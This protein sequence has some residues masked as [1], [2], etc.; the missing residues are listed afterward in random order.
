LTLPHGTSSRDSRTIER[1]ARE[2]G[3]TPRS[4]QRRLK[5]EGSSFQVVRDEVRREL[6]ISY[7]ERRLPVTE[8][9]FLLGFSDP[10]AFCRAFK[11]WTGVPPLESRGRNAS[12]P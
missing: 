3:L 11:R 8:I 4:R 10:S 1:I 7:L 6:A 12:R 2:L 9:A 5:D